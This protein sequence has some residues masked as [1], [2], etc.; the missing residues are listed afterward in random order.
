MKSFGLRAGDW[1]VTGKRSLP[2]PCRAKKEKAEKV[3][4][5]LGH[6]VFNNISEARF[7]IAG[8]E[9]SRSLGMPNIFLGV[10]TA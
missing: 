4:S 1:K 3:I 8:N 9:E 10:V 6:S 2:D 7:Q 5:F